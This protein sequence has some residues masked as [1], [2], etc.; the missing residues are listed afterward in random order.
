MT[1]NEDDVT[2]CFLP[3]SHI[4][5]RGSCQF[6]ALWQGACI[7]YADSPA[8]LLDDMQK[9]NPTWINCIPRL[10][11]KIYITF[12]EQMSASPRRKQI[13]DWA[14]KVGYEALEYRKDSRGC[15]NMDPNFDLKSKLPFNLKLK[16]A[17]ADKLFAKVRAL[18]GSRYRFSFSASAS[19]APDLLRFYY[20]LGIPVCEGYG[21]TESFNS[22]VLNPL[23]ACKPGSIGID[24]NGGIG[25]VAEDGELELSGAGIFV[26][27]LN[28]P[29]ENEA[30]FTADGW[31]RSGDLVQQDEDGYY[32]MVD[33]KKAI[34]CL[35]IGKNVAPLKIEALFATSSVIE[36]VFI[37][38]DERRYI[39]ALLVPNY[40]FFINLFEREGIPYDKSK[41]VY[42]DINGIEMCVEVGEDFISQPRLK[43]LIE[44]DVKA[45]SAYL[46]EFESIKKYSILSHRFTEEN[47]QLTPTQKTKKSVILKDYESLIES[48]YS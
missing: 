30:A 34:I 24:S 9:Y 48:M 7:A 10:Y 19:I 36:Q 32:R 27:Y 6:M 13:F 43:E 33:R 18:F 39:T 45:S 5:D 46:E 28:K 44:N 8:T 40:G 12:N 26:G 37:I 2:L 23:T 35:S 21:L 38:G 11:E 1:L 47:G 3:L 29:E 20:A 25:R 16:Y 31:F 14:L 41:L 22:C 15:Y 42:E 4:F 17:I